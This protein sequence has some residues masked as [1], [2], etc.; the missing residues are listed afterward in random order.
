MTWRRERKAG[1]VAIHTLC[2]TKISGRWWW[3]NDTMIITWLNQSN[4]SVTKNQVRLS[5]PS[6]G[7]ITCK[8]KGLHLNKIKQGKHEGSHIICWRV[9]QLL[10]TQKSSTI[11]GQK[12]LQPFICLGNH[13]SGSG[14]SKKVFLIQSNGC[15][16]QSPKKFQQLSEKG[17]KSSTESDVNEGTS[18][19]QSA[20]L[21]IKKSKCEDNSQITK[22]RKALA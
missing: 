7:N 3:E 4:F 2:D 15:K 21:T 1:Q 18:Y 16:K 9:I 19:N 11:P 12:W 5:L 17:D 22:K 10:S 6:W 13:A 14:F 8:R 20:H